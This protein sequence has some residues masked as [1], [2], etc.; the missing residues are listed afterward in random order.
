MT[1]FL[2]T[3][4][5]AKHL[6]DRYGHGSERTLTKLRCVG[7]GPEFHRSGRTV[8]YTPE[9]LDKWATAKISPPLRSTSDTGEAR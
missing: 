5:A 8:I 3:P 2:R 7:G 1:N 9:A 6:K 4:A